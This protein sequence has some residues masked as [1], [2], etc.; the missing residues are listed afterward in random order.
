MDNRE[1]LLAQVRKQVKA[2]N[3][4]L[5]NLD[6]KGYYNSFSSKKLFERLGGSNSMLKMSDGKVLGVSINKNASM[7]DLHRLS[8]ATKNFLQSETSTPR[9]IRNVVKR[10]KESMYRTLSMNPE[11]DIDMADIETYYDMLGDK[12]FDFFNTEDRI[13]ASTMWA[14]IDEAIV[15][16]EKNKNYSKEDFIKMFG[17]TNVDINDDDIKDRLINIYNKYVL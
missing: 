6:A 4:K 9:S 12:D 8:K 3:R 1:E 2:T 7:T 15:E 14:M 11:R 16:K 13:G 10:T 5:K 17:T